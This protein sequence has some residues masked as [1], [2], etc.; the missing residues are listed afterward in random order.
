[1]ERDSYVF[2][3]EMSVRDYECD[4]QGIVNNSVYQNYIE[5]VRHLYLK[6]VGIDF[7]EYTRQGI[8]LVV[9]RAELDYKYPLAS[10]DSFVVGLTMCRESTLKFAFYQDIFRIPDHKLV[11]KAK[12]IG[13]ALNKRGRPEIPEALA[14][15]FT[16]GVE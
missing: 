1:M 15:L 12:I 13:T 5:H 8:N 9:V 2:T 11:L 7:S 6:K 16:S 10:G 14:A 4:M 3:C